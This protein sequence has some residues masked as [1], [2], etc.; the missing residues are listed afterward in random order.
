M[1]IVHAILG[2]LLDGERHGYDIAGT[3]ADRVGGG[4]YNSGQVH[5]ALEQLEERGWAVSHE[6]SSFARPRRIFSVTAGGRNEFF[7][8]L[9][10]PV[11]I[12]RP[13]RDEMVVKMVFLG[14]HDLSLLIETLEQRQ[15]S[16]V[17]RL[18]RLQRGVALPKTNGPA[19]PIVQL[20]KDVFRFREEAELK[21]IEHCLSQL[22]VELGSS[23]VAL[24][25]EADEAH[26]PGVEANRNR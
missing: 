4:P 6:D 7:T 8:W 9:K 21:W 14:V 20:A 26:G 15:R 2:V 22:G 13:L 19:Q 12:S 17:R 25:D 11:P 18:A 3:L 24:S 5:Q 10:A 1:S 16:Y 23:D